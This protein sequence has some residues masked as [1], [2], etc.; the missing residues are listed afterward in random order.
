MNKITRFLIKKE[1][2]RQGLKIIDKIER[3]N[4]QD[5][6]YL[7]VLNSGVKVNL[8]RIIKKAREYGIKQAKRII[9]EV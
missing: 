7:N 8:S 3:V 5:G 6:L 2:K 1:L 9:K 4:L